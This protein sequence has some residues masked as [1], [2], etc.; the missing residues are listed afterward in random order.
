MPS[1]VAL[2]AAA[3]GP[4][5][6]YSATSLQPSSTWSAGGSSGAFN[7]SYPMRVPPATGGPAPQVQLGYSSQSVDGRHAASNNQ[8][9]WMG[10]GFEA[11]P[12]GFVERQYKPCARDMNGSANND[13]ETGDQ[14][15]ET[16]NATL[17]LNGTSGELLYNA[18]EGRWHLR[19][20]EGARIER[21]TGASNGDNNGEHWVVTTTDGIQ[22][23]F[24]LNRLPGWVS[25]KPETNS[26]WTVPVFGNDPGEPCHATAFP[27]SDC[28]QAWRWNLDYV[29]D[30]HSNT[31]S[32]WYGKE[33]NKYARNLDPDDDADY[34]RAGWLDRI[35][36][37]T[38]RAGGTDSVFNSPSPFRVEFNESDRCVSN[39][40]THDE[41]HWPDTPWDSSCTGPSCPDKFSPTFW[42]TK[43][44]ASVTTQ[45]RAGA[46]Y[47]D[48]ERWTFSHSFP[49]PGDGTRAG[50][51]LDKISHVGLAGGSVN[52][53]DIEFTPVQLSN[54]VDT[55]DFAAAMNW[56]RI[57]KI[58]N[59]T[60]GTVSVT[61]SDQ[62]CKA[63]ETMPAVHT[64]VRL[65]YPVIWEPEG[66]PAPVTDWFHKYVVKTIYES[67]NTGGAPPQGSPRV[68]YKYDYYDGAAWHYTDD[69]GLV[70][71]KYKTWSD[72]RGYG[73][74]G[75]TVGDPGEQTYSE[76]R[77]FRGM[78][79][80][81]ASPSGGIR[82]VKIDGIN[83]EDWH[84]GTVR[85]TIN[86]NGPSGSVVNR[87]TNEPWLSPVTATRTI[88]GDTVT[89]RFNRI[90]ATRSYTA[91]DAGRADRVT[92]IANSF[93]SYGMPVQVDDLGEES[94]PGDEKCTKSEYNPRN[95]GSWIMDRV[96]STKMF[97]VKCADT[98]GA[99]TDE[100]F[101]SELRTSYDAQSFGTAPTRGLPTQTEKA[102]AWNSGAPTFVTQNRAAYDTQGRVTSTWDG[103]G[104]ETK[105]AYTPSVGGPVTALT[106]T[107]PLQHV[108]V[109]N[110]EPAW[111][112][113]T[114]TVDANN[115]TTN[116]AYDPLGRLTAVWLPGR[117][118]ATKKPNLKYTYQL[119]AVAPT[120]VTT[121]RLN[122]A[123]D[124]V[125]SFALLDGL[126]RQRQTQNAS[127][128]GGRLLTDAFYDSAGREAVKYGTYHAS[129]SAGGTLSTAIDRALVPNQSST[130]YD[131]ISRVTAT[132][133]QPYNVERWRTKT[134]YAG[135]RTDVTAP[136][137]SPAASSTV[138]DAR[139]RTVELRQYHGAT[140]TP[141][142]PGSW[143]STR[144]TIDRRGNL[145]NVTDAANNVWA[146][147]YDTL[148]RQTE[149]RD[150][151]RGKTTFTYDKNDRV[152][153]S[154]DARDKKLAY[155]YDSLNR[156]RA[157]YDNQVGGTQ[158]A[159]WIYDTLA[160][161]RITQ[162]TRFVGSDAYQVKALGYTDSYELT[163]SQVIIPASETGLAGTYNFEKTWNIDGSLASSS[164]PSTNGDLP[165]ETLT[166]GYDGFGGLKTVGT[167]YG[168]T[169]SSY[170]ADTDYNALGQIEQVEL[171]SGS[172]GRVF[173]AFTREKETG[174]LLG[175]RT[176][177]DQ[178]AP[179]ILSDVRYTYN[180]A[181][182]IT[183]I[184]DVAADPVDDTQC[185]TYDYLGRLTEAWTPASS[186][187]AA[188]R[189][190]T[191]L[192]GPAPY[193][194]SWTYDKVGN[195]KQE[196][197]HGTG[198][199]AVTNYTYP[200]AGST[201]PHTLSS[202]TGARPGT[203]TYDAMGN[204]LTRP[205]SGA[206]TQSLTWDNEAFLASSTDATGTTSYIYDADGN[207]LIRRDPQGRTLYLPEQ[208]IRYSNSTQSRSCTRY[209][210]HNGSPVASR[211]ATKLTW[212]A[213]DHQGTALVS[214]DA[215][216]QSQTIRRQSPFGAARG[217]AS[218]WP[219]TRGFVGGT[220]DN[221]GLTHLGAREYD[222]STGRFISSDEVMDLTNPQQMHGYT[223]AHSNPVAYADPT[224]N[225]E[226]GND[227]C[228]MNSRPT[229]DGGEIITMP[230]GTKEKIGG[231]GGGT[232]DGRATWVS[233][234]CGKDPTA[235]KGC[236][237]SRPNAGIILGGAIVVAPTEAE[238]RAAVTEE[239]DRWC[240]GGNGWADR[241]LGGAGVDGCAPG[242]GGSEFVESA[243]KTEICNDHPDWCEYQDLSQTFLI[244]GVAGVGYA[245][246]GKTERRPPHTA[247]V[248]YFDSSGKLIF[249]T[250]LRSGNMTA[251][252]RAKGF[253][254]N[255]LA[256]HTERR[257]M[258]L[259]Y[260]AE[261]GF[262]VIEGQYRACSHCKG[263]M[264]ETAE[265]RNV[266]I[267][268]RWQNRV[269]IATPQ[270][271]G[272][273]YRKMIGRMTRSR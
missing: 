32:Y 40:T 57:T 227:D 159:Q 185:Y 118:I 254:L 8:P 132:V 51:W 49:D 20:D 19:N 12:G 106:V 225:L 25:E 240:K 216:T 172:G 179:N 175:I 173:Q 113:T 75:V 238:L 23:W 255:S 262:V 62:D 84:A 17:S 270:A 205:T 104:Y 26:T 81:K 11:W 197:V 228:S 139:D 127:P 6:D 64:N 86:F 52:V 261:G 181:G 10:E 35:D 82:D 27:D 252:D 234:G 178:V 184:R 195:R 269:W 243:I 237:P 18:V 223:Y 188:T 183:Q 101:I 24:G 126:L 186:D 198:S 258:V 153:T 90:A 268:Y 69:D 102:S 134:Y 236:Q 208:E 109:T 206:G 61:Y 231:T 72:F 112:L 215:A 190:V 65:C 249:E 14:C 241:L 162:S 176:D 161:G 76:T 180:K 229:S 3:S 2:E 41:A 88:N 48:V 209:Y 218:P 193:W 264:R 1:V 50:L 207:R 95:G 79:G 85:E 63:G 160:K 157:V 67:D 214:V 137:G 230:D 122:A 145:T 189:S 31:A 239:M 163:G 199:D 59:E 91:R 267:A 123:E 58:R 71:K 133:F 100:D 93:D 251:A 28:V 142:T 166:Y 83:D 99:L 244:Q 60:G 204:T 9:S 44:L 248:S 42:T 30:L 141:G 171:Y 226:C 196:T 272:A 247:K 167:L 37:G 212:L 191:G 266:T 15:W 128:S 194:H 146:Y 203:Y 110:F 108:A 66:H 154:M 156:K 148:G 45:V 235:W 182:N 233:N 114:S 46:G 80:D 202:T 210:S 136:E 147:S 92:K 98:G 135:D 265:N 150:P 232:G 47:R 7:W 224:G 56:M 36:Y 111:G 54:R 152:A 222:S 43:R 68:V 29:I 217:T 107:N 220:D 116:M 187:C 22:Y 73:R 138:T 53:P 273:N 38:R 5:G 164:F 174:R 168:S 155:L 89:A 125:E 119:S 4:A 246:F 201:K 169:Q 250:T 70:E 149:S 120:V 192:G 259:P 115:K 77:Y 103:I 97:G 219:N 170:V 130:V 144:F 121:S 242:V 158:R 213:A 143:D 87:Q 21:R 245:A 256:T 221:T 253:P 271:S 39:C 151:D 140:P 117:D 96:H 165:L 78:H 55:E 74:V 260:V 13:K 200:A 105:T 263:A 94:V 177:R 257:A 16:D 211:T 131:G 33:S 124:Y 34:V 129:G